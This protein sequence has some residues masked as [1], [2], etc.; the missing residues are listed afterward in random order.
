MRTSNANRKRWNDKVGSDAGG[1]GEGLRSLL[2][3]LTRR[4]ASLPTRGTIL[5]HA[6]FFLR[7]SVRVRLRLPV[8]PRL[9]ARFSLD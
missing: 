1:G 8:F 7:P 9:R 2:G 5:T 6:V 4:I 3:D